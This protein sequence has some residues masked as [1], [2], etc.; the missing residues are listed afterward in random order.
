MVFHG[1]L[2]RCSSLR[3]DALTVAPGGLSGSRASPN[4]QINAQVPG[5]VPAFPGLIIIGL[6]EWFLMPA[7]YMTPCHLSADVTMR[8]RHPM[9]SPTDSRQRRAAMTWAQRLNRVFNMDCGQCSG[10]ARVIA[11][12]EDPMVIWTILDHSKQRVGTIPHAPCRALGAADSKRAYRSHRTR[13]FRFR[14]SASVRDC[15]GC[16]IV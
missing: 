9:G 1:N 14:A 6:R 7:R 13:A 12:I 11:C 16:L 10:P 8:P 2:R 3:P 5:V 15:M 4:T